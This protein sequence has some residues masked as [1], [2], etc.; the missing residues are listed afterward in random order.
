MGI[1]QS[2]QF[3]TKM[4]KYFRPD[5]EYSEEAGDGSLIPAV[6]TGRAMNRQG[7]ATFRTLPFQFL[8]RN[9]F[10]K[11][12]ITD[13]LKIL[14]HAHAIACS[15]AFIQLFKPTAGEFFTVVAETC[16]GSFDFRAVAYDAGSTIL[17]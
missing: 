13:K 15:I 5:A 7:P 11:S 8:R 17:G 6:H 3:S 1:R 2:R 16:T 14:Q 10:F 9:E 4:S 12:M